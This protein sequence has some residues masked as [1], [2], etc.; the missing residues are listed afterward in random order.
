MAVTICV[1]LF[2]LATS[3]YWPGLLKFKGYS[4]PRMVE[5]LYLAMDEGMFGFLTGISSS[6]LFIY[7]LFAG[8]MLHAGVGGFLID[9]AVWAA[10]WTKGGPAKIAV[11]S[12]ALYGL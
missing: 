10:G 1:A 3:P 8:F 9:F 11:I 2:Y 4:Y 6:I 7:I 5:V 12:S